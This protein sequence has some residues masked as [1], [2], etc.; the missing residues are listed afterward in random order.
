MV[1]RSG[2]TVVGSEYMYKD[3]PETCTF[4]AFFPYIIIIII[5][6]L[7]LLLIIIIIV[8]LFQE[9]NISGTNVSLTSVL[10]YKD[11]QVFDN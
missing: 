10:N 11:T 1:I 9:D 6:L 8:T 2:L 3:V 7:L 4:T 5:L